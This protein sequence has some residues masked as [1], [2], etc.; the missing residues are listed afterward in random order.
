MDAFG[1]Y[2]NLIW[3][4]ILNNRNDRYKSAKMIIVAHFSLVIA[5]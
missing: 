2:L 5:A 1:G 3:L 4:I